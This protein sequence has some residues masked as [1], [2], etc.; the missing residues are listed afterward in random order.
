ME[1]L[2]DLDSIL[3]DCIPQE[4]ANKSMPGL[5]TTSD[6]A[7]TPLPPAKPDTNVTI[8]APASQK[9]HDISIDTSQLD[10]LLSKME[11]APPAVPATP[12][13]TEAATDD[14]DTSQLD[15][16]INKM[17][18]AEMSGNN[19]TQTSTQLQRDAT[20]RCSECLDTS[21][22]DALI[23]QMQQTTTATAIVT[24]QTDATTTT[25]T[26]ATAAAAAPTTKV[27]DVPDR[28]E[29]EEMRK[30]DN[31]KES[32]DTSLSS[33]PPQAPS[34]ASSAIQSP[35]THE[36]TTPKTLTLTSPQNT[37]E[38]N[39]NNNNINPSSH[40][41]PTTD[42]SNSPSSSSS[43]SS[44]VA[45]TAA[46]AEGKA[47]PL[48]VPS[49]GTDD[50]FS[51][52]PEILNEMHAASLEMQESGYTEDDSN[53]MYGPSSGSP[54]PPVSRK[55]PPL[56]QKRFAVYTSQTHGNEPQT[57][58]SSS[59]AP[60]PAAAT[61]AAGIEPKQ[62]PIPQQAQ[63]ATEFPMQIVVDIKE[64]NNP[65]FQESTYERLALDCRAGVSQYAGRD[66]DM[67]W[68]DVR[69]SVAHGIWALMN[70]DNNNL[71]MF[72]D[73]VASFMEKNEGATCPERLAGVL[74]VLE[75]C[76]TAVEQT[77]VGFLFPLLEAFFAALAFTPHQVRHGINLARNALNTQTLNA[78]FVSHFVPVLRGVCAHFLSSYARRAAV[79]VCKRQWK[80]FVFLRRLAAVT[81]WYNP[82]KVRSFRHLIE[83]ER[84][85]AEDLRAADENIRTPLLEL[86]ANADTAVLTAEEVNT[87]FAQFCVLRDTQTNLLAALDEVAKY[88]PQLYY[89]PDLVVAHAYHFTAY[90]KQH[91]NSSNNNN[92]NYFFPSFIDDYVI[93]I[94]DIE[95]RIALLKKKNKAFTTFLE[96]VTNHYIHITHTHTH[97]LTLSIYN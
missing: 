92:N 36:M 39:N 4:D 76:D 41:L 95:K 3:Q 53:D 54:P 30:D 37:T 16:L 62:P 79:L 11:Q 51:S 8:T 18:Q 90:S 89:G 33:S 56:P 69:V 81:R 57:T 22:L 96:K 44:A 55:T 17:E 6:Q 43:S 47:S 27:I 28:I 61:A 58:P 40:S 86:A 48:I 12:P 19:S 49:W 97:S 29:R 70:L 10:D 26:D 9:S 73:L 85:L 46:A 32:L 63:T 52:L 60:A 23:T 45:A 66:M 83:D 2:D 25:T 65:M 75:A 74:R 21:Q 64:S 5:T 68:E 80:R 59:P 71:S 88:W 13:T 14:L 15:D 7:Q 24:P 1:F 84:A 91:N 93:G 20:R 72:E 38:S 35:Q 87:L 50:S 78:W 42:N 31:D 34:G 67:V 82:Q 94:D 77:E